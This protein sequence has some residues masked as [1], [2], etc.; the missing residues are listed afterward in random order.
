MILTTRDLVFRYPSGVV[1][2]DGVNLTIEFGDSVAIIGEN[3]AGK[4]TL[5]KHFNGLLRPTSGSV[6][7]GDWSTSQHSAAKLARRVAFVFQNP[8]DQ[9]FARTVREEVAFGA[10]NL[11]ASASQVKERVDAALAE[12]GL[13]DHSESH[14]YDLPS[15]S[16]KF[17]TLAAALV[18]QTPILVLDE[19]TIGQDARGLDRMAAIIERHQ[20]SGQT[21]IVIS[22]DLDFCAEHF[23]RTIVMAGG[24]ILL[25]GPSPSV[26][27]QAALLAQ[28]QVESPD[29]IR[30]AQAIGLDASPCT[31]D[32]FIEAYAASR[33]KEPKS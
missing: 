7:I 33:S 16:R 5:A 3:G 29:L 4:T 12:V 6:L 13:I 8:D 2:L 10:R 28:A 25:D 18:M 30:L 21:V 11:G 32:E 15:S 23:R 24:K 26:L 14:P 31:V 1:A 22:H 17:V 19:P 20:R 9:L 27:S